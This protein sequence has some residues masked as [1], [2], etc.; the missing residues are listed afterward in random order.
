MKLVINSLDVV[1]TND[2]IDQNNFWDK[3]ILKK[4]WGQN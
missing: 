1:R 2:K 3:L 4:L